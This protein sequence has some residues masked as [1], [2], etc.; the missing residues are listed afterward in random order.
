MKNS[1]TILMGAV[2]AAALL[3]YMFLYQVRYDQ[4]AVRTT[5]D[6]ADDEGS[7]QTDPGLKFRLPWPIH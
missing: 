1:F 6:K 3:S 5:F 7:V 2:I 4:V